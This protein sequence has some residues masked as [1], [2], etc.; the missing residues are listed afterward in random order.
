[1][2]RKRRVPGYCLH[3]STGQAYV[4]LGGKFHYL[5]THGSQASKDRYD[6]LLSDWLAGRLAP[7]GDGPPVMTVGEVAD[8][9]QEYAENY[10]R[11]GG[12]ATGQLERVKIAL[13]PVRTLYGTLAATAFGPKALRKARSEM[14]R[15]GWTRTFINSCVGC[16][17]RAWAWAVSE[18][19]VPGPAAAALRELPALRRGEEG[20]RE[21]KT[22][23][24]VPWERVE[25]TLPFLRPALRDLLTV[26]YLAG[27]RP[28]EAVHLRARDIDFGGRVPDGP[29]FPGLWVYIVP[30]EANKMHHAG[31]PRYVF[32]GPRA[33]QLLKPYLARRKPEE[34]LFSPKESA[35]AW[36]AGRTA[37]RTT[38]LW[39]SHADAN[40]RK[41]KRD[42]KRKPR[43]RYDSR[44]LQH[45][46]ARACRRAGVPHW[47]PNQLRHSRAT[48]I[49]AQAD[50]GAAG[51]VLGHAS[52]EVT[53][54]YAEEALEKAAG[55]M[56]RVG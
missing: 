5:G 16:V 17:V 43:E 33:Q 7:R 35:A 28:V 25:K 40:T 47:S 3:K 18:E 1:M 29:H 49:R 23:R 11:K 20:V 2:S 46:V 45:A 44:G 10:Y 41:R 30:P 4:C 42:P 53:K 56:G 6:K 22:V 51:A 54:R 24:P 26:Q 21:G 32:L 12:K 50:L 38:K 31:R 27:M 14:V 39:D 37:A 15:R 55:V 52:L 8:R 19:M 36:H 34:Y 48:E 13:G 9:Y